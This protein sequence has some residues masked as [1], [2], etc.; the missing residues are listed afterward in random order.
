MKVVGVGLIPWGLVGALLIAYH[1]A[2]T[3]RAAGAAAMDERLRRARG[4]V[5]AVVG[6]ARRIRD[7]RDEARSDL[8]AD[9]DWMRNIESHGLTVLDVK[10]LA[11]LRADSARVA[12]A[13]EEARTL[14]CAL[15]LI[16]DGCEVPQQ[17]AVEALERGGEEAS[18][19]AN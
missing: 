2:E 19:R 13:D 6:V 1:V 10:H 12:S 15:E 8:E 5:R 17:I 9:R 14:R 4:R 7:E 11:G 3:R 16:A 18:C